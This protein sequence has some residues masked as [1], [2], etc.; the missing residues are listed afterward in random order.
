MRN[1]PA[2]VSRKYSINPLS[3]STPHNPLSNKALHG[4]KSNAGLSGAQTNASSGD[5]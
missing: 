5:Y 4:G 3:A 1:N 2:I